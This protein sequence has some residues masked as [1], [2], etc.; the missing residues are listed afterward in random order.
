MNTVF[1]DTVGLIALWEVT[2]QWHP[3][4]ERAMAELNVSK[5]RLITTEFI[6]Q[7]CGNAAA[8]KPYRADVHQLRRSFASDGRIIM[9]TQS[10]IDQAWENYRR[11]SAGTAGIVDHVSFIVMRRLGIAEVFG[12]DRH[13]K[14]AGFYTLF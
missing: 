12:N 7:E 6:L 9:P 1:L 14:A 11:G 5:S 3:A 10:D 8:R 2:D 13:F 4:A